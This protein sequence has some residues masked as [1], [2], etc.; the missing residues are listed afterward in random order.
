MKASIGFYEMLGLTL[1]I[2]SVPRYCRFEFPKNQYG[3]RASLSLD[4][5]DPNWVA[6]DGPLIYFE[7][8]DLDAYLEDIKVKPIAPAK[9]QTYLWREA[10]ILDPAGNRIRLYEAGENRRFPPW[11][12][13]QKT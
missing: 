3:E 7:V 5:V 4:Q 11:R 6:G 9:T 12:V 1:I 10:D 2:D 13:S 8:D